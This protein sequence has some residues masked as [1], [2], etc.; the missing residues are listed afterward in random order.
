MLAKQ[1]VIM[2]FGIVRRG[3]SPSGGAERYALRFAKAVEQA[4]HQCILFCSQ[5]WPEESWPGEYMELG[6]VGPLA[7]ADNL[8]A[9][10]PKAYCD[11]LFSLERVWRADVF[12][13]GDG[14]HKNWLS[15]RSR[16]EGWWSA[17][18]RRWSAKHREILRLEQSLFSGGAEVVIANS[19]F[20]KAQIE[21]EY[22]T[23]SSRI[24]VVHNGVE[25]FKPDFAARGRLCEE[26]GMR[27]DAF[28]ILFAGSGWERKGLKQ[29]IQAVNRANIPGSVLLV[30]GRGKAAGLPRSRRVVFLGE[31]NDMPSIYSASDL[32]ILPTWYDPFS[33]A[34][35]EALSAGLPVVTTSGNGF[36]ELVKPGI[37]GEVVQNPRDVDAL[38]AALK[39]WSEMSRRMESRRYLRE[40]ASRFSVAENVAQTLEVV[41]ASLGLK[42]ADQPQR[43]EGWTPE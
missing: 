8:E 12:R 2:R 9:S 6:E 20:V 31:R 40:Y 22:G 4:G 7:F 30:A 41:F 23:P 15:I 33:N 18:F 27:S 42:G 3:F 16:F 19:R 43:A 5:A 11:V 10:D 24:K 39:R 21:A 26:I 34:S 13:A 38:A 35:L 37:H 36:S 17:P 32:F 25:P 1:R 29:P 14:V 28:A